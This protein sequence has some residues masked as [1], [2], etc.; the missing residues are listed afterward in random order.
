MSLKTTTADNFG[1]SAG[2][3]CDD[4]DNDTY[5]GVVSARNLQSIQ[6]AVHEWPDGDRFRLDLSPD[7]ITRK[8]H[9][10]ALQAAREARGRLGKLRDVLLGERDGLYARLHQLS[11]GAT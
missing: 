4:T 7:E 9:R 11:Y 2:D 8:R 3:I 5:Q 1:G 6:V 10:A